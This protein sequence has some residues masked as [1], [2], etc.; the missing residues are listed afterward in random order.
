[1]RDAS[2]PRQSIP[3]RYSQLDNIF[4]ILVWAALVLGVLAVSALIADFFGRK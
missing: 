3:E 4:L 1:M 2:S